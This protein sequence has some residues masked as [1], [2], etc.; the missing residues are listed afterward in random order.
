M[1]NVENQMSKECRSPNTESVC[2][3]LTIAAS[4]RDPAER[5]DG[6]R[7]AVQAVYRTMGDIAC[8]RA[9]PA[10]SPPDCWRDRRRFRFRLRRQRSGG[11]GRGEGA[12]RMYGVGLHFDLRR[13]MR[14]RSDHT[15]DFRWAPSPPALSPKSF[16]SAPIRIRH[17]SR[18]Q[19]GGE[20]AFFTDGD[21]LPAV[22]QCKAL[23]AD[24]RHSHFDIPST[25]V[26]PHSSFERW[27]T[28]R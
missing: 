11:E 28:P 20:G 4:R 23:H 3:G 7:Q 25:F 18:E 6:N 5:V 22:P 9:V 1:T 13:S 24:I 21:R 10:P 15:Q 12:V 14:H 16:A 26:I 17:H 2:H 19:F 27:A 8:W